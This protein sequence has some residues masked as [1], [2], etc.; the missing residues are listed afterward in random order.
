MLRDSLFYMTYELPTDDLGYKYK[1]IMCPLCSI[2]LQ[3]MCK[4]LC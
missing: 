2:L 1:Y 3:A 4:L